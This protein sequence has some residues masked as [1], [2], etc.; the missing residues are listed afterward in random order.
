MR[1]VF[2][3][4]LSQLTTHKGPFVSHLSLVVP[5]KPANSGGLVVKNGRSANVKIIEKDVPLPVI[6]LH[7]APF[8]T[9]GG[10]ID[11]GAYGSQIEATVAL[12]WRGRMQLVACAAIALLDCDIVLPTGMWG[13]E[14]VVDDMREQSYEPPRVVWANQ[15]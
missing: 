12:L 5:F 6:G 11:A 10:V 2:N 4:D 15:A 7:M 9:L 8:Y 1:T 13:G 3:A 14:Q